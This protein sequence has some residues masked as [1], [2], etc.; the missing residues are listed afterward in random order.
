MEV[1]D[2]LY[3]GKGKL[4]IHF[5]KCI[6][7]QIL[8]NVWGKAGFNVYIKSFKFFYSQQ[9][10][11]KDPKFIYLIYFYFHLIHFNFQRTHTLFNNIAST[12]GGAG[13]NSPGAFGISTENKLGKATS[14]EADGGL[15][16]GGEGRENRKLMPLKSELN[17]NNI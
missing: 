2:L 14:I 1:G 5:F 11:K 17:R 7:R 3:L 12:L 4:S 10:Y 9:F 13:N 15:V 8:I 6:Q 16:M